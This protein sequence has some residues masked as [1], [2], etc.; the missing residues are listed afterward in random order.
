MTWFALAVLLVLGLWRAFA[1]AW[2]CDDSFISIRYAENLANGLG[3]VYNA[4]EYVEGYTNLSWTLLLAAAAGW[5]LSPVATAKFLGIAFYAALILVL[6]RWS[7]RRARR[8]GAPFLPLAAGLVLVSNDFHVWATGGLETMLFAYLVT[9]AL[10]LTRLPAPTLT[11][12]LGAGAIMGLLVLTRLDGLLF[13]AAGCVSYFFP[14][15]RLAPRE[16][17]IHAGALVFPV[18]VVLAILIP[19]KLFYYGELVPTAFYSKSVLDPYV[20]Q[21][22][23]YV[24]L[25]LAKNWFLVPTMIALFLLGR[26]K[27]SAN[28]NPTSRDDVFFIGTALVFIGYLIEVGGDFMFARRLIPVIPAIFVAAEIRLARIEGPHL[29]NA[30]SLAVLAAAALPMPLYGEEP[31]AISGVYDERLSYPE[32]I[33]TMREMQGRTVGAALE[34][35]GARVAFEGGMC[36][37]GYYSGLPYLAE[38][39]GLTQY[40]LAKRPLAERGAVGHEKAPD[41]AWFDENRI[42]FLVKRDR[43]PLPDPPEGGRIDEIRFGDVARARILVYSDEVMDPLRDRSGISFEPIEAVIARVAGMME[44]ASLDRAERMYDQ[45]ERYYLRT[46]G[47]RGRPFGDRLRRIVE[48]KRLSTSSRP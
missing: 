8:G 9:H 44:V 43:T 34:G 42:H 19:A 10:L 11:R 40:S 27:V 41:D 2:L 45:I 23:V 6:V 20:S 15:G 3:L 12:S 48:R 5:G 35:T 21:G 7:W 31:Q 25:Y 26:G 39:T 14:L 30:I 32:E 18:F 46:A 13:V 33:M 24:G 22:L 16:R 47:V 37:F 1:L 38:T 4:G 29:R 28:E 17:W 36:V